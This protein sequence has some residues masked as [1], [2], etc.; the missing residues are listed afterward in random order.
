MAP[1]AP[2]PVRATAT[3]TTLTSGSCCASASAPRSLSPGSP[4]APPRT[5]G[6]GSPGSLTLAPFPYPLAS[7]RGAPR[8]ANQR[9]LV[10]REAEHALAENIAQDLRGARAGPAAPGQGRVEGPLPLVGGP[11]ARRLHLGVRADHLRRH[12]GQILVHLAPEELGGGALGPGH[13]ALQDSRETPVAVEL[14]APL[15]DAQAR[16]LLAHH[17]VLGCRAPALPR[18]P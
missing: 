12:L 10:F 6:C 4:A 17:R 18:P 3:T 8:L 15:G 14:Q 16:D 2:K 9:T 5:A 13:D 11:G 1:P 7:T